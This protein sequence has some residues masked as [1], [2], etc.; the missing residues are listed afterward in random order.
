MKL[1]G[2]V[3]EHFLKVREARLYKLGKFERFVASD[4]DCFF[5]FL[6]QEKTQWRSSRH[7]VLVDKKFRI[8]RLSRVAEGHPWRGRGVL[9]ERSCTGIAREEL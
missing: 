2:G 6:I 5:L 1:H 8:E 3:L 4:A 9:A 7:C